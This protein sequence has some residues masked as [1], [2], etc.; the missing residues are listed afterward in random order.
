MP[1]FLSLSVISLHL[2][3]WP[4]TIG[5]GLEPK[6]GHS[7]G[8]VGPEILSPG[9]FCWQPLASRTRA[10]TSAARTIPARPIKDLCIPSPS[11]LYIPLYEFLAPYESVPAPDFS[12]GS[13]VSNPRGYSAVRNSGL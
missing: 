2:T 7:L 8:E 1:N 11:T 5:P 4:V 10:A 12:P 13:G 3:G 6:P 9:P